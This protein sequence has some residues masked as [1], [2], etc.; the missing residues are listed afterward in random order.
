MSHPRPLHGSI[1]ACAGEPGAAVQC[2]RPSWVYPRVCGGARSGDGPSVI[3]RGLSPRVRGS[4]DL[5]LLGEIGL[6]SIPA[7]AGEPRTP[8][9]S[10]KP[11]RV[12]PRV[13]GGAIVLSGGRRIIE[14]LSPRVRGSPILPNNTTGLIGSIPA[15]AGEPSP[16]AGC[17]RRTGVYPRVCGGAFACGPPVGPYTGLSPRVRG[18]RNWTDIVLRASGSIP[19]CAGEPAS[20]GRAVTFRGVY[21]RVCGGAVRESRCQPSARVYP[22]VCGGAAPMLLP[23][24]PAVGLSPRVRG[25]PELS[26]AR[27]GVL[28]SIPACAGEPLSNI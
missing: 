9:R 19:A 5:L 22:R 1:P 11:T 20:G 13:C 18:S 27:P 23:P 7:C 3:M 17:R 26:T 2:R 12:Y 15:C 6:G 24:G 16:A 8:S 25:S 21:P 14:G 4:H 28:G 10:R